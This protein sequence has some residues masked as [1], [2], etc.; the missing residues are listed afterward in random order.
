MFVKK[1]TIGLAML[2]WA[3]GSLIQVLPAAGK[4]PHAVRL[5]AVC[6]GR[7][8]IESTNYNGKILVVGR[9]YTMV[10]KPSAGW[11]FTN[12]TDGYGLGVTNQPRFTFVMK[13]NSAFIANFVKRSSLPGPLAGVSIA[14][15]PMKVLT[16][17]NAAPEA[18]QPQVL[19]EWIET[20]G[21]MHPSA[22][23]SV[24][25]TVLTVHP[26]LMPPAVTAAITASPATIYPLIETVAQVPGVDLIHIV[27]IACAAMPGQTFQI[28][29]AVLDAD[30]T[31]GHEVLQAVADAVPEL[32]T[33]IEPALAND[34]GT[35]SQKQALAILSGAM[36]SINWP[37]TPGHPGE[38]P[39]DYSR[40]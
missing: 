26:E 39:Q 4:A 27:R 14:D 18:T 1:R 2:L 25:G 33:V 9:E 13:T 12:W 20:V 28:V 31:R 29:K 5:T 37:I 8:T 24:L 11:T 3:M 34:P 32:A 30:P 38:N 16:A 19:T 15:I 40:P 35:L 6:R 36:T 17:V 23:P 22:L 10:A 7:G 21:A